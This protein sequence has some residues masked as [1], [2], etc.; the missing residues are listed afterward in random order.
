MK[1]AIII[2]C[3][4]LLTLLAGCSV[5]SHLERR[6]SRAEAA[7]PPR[8]TV[9]PRVTPHARPEVRIDSA[10]YYLAG[11]DTD[12]N[13]ERIMAETIEEVVVVARSRTV[14]ERNG[15][16]SVDFVITLPRE[17][18]GNCRSVTVT[19]VLHHRDGTQSLQELSIRGGLFSRVQDRNYWQFEQYVRIFRPDAYRKQKAFE[20]FVKWPYP[21]GVRLDS[22]VERSEEIAYYY[23]QRVPTKGEG[24]TLRITLHGQVEG[25]DGSS[26]LLPASD[27]LQ[28]NI[29]SMLSFI[30]RT[31][32]YRIR[33]I[34][35]YM[36]VNDRNSIL[37]LAGDTRVV[38]TLG[39]NQ[40]QLNR[41]NDLMRQI[42][43]QEEFYVDTITLTAASSPEGAYVFNDRLSKGRAEAL[44][45]YL[46]QQFGPRIDTMLSVRWIA[47]DWP[48]LTARIRIDPK[49]GNRDAILELIAA[50]RNPDR[51]EYSIRQRFPK[52]YAYIKS[53]IYPQLR[54]VNFR[55][56]LRR[57]GM[58]KDTIHTMESDTHYAEGIKLLDQRHYHEAAS[59]LAPYEDMNS[60]IAMLSAGSDK[61]AYD[62]LSR[63][64]RSDT[65]EYLL[66]IAC[67][68]LGRIEE[69]RKH[70]EEACR[71]N[72][73]FKYRGDLDPEIGNLLKVKKE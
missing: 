15:A 25:L 57:K 3:A 40:Q 67:A 24:K 45:H 33:I 19:P 32:R 14:A 36:T 68:R 41:I 4:T 73:N 5:V 54:A 20:R 58:I 49:I 23:T 13:G 28:Y 35:K 48:E 31:P 18:Q 29:S 47:E 26:Y 59:I 22:I 71:M 6:Q 12:E 64:K 56:S 2:C 21:E 52:D 60:A 7:Y 55:Y 37:F 39:D 63:I 51:R 66:A 70:Y 69:G 8:R 9:P 42:I 38:D 72:E 34:D 65:V 61:Q 62:V 43:A 44:K 53:V 17:M 46:G 10:I 11:V 30:D 50:E 27:T 1:Y 16:V